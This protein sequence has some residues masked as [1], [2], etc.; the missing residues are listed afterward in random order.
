[1]CPNRDSEDSIHQSSEIGAFDGRHAFPKVPQASR[2]KQS[3]LRAKGIPTSPKTRTHP[4]FPLT[5]SVYNRSAHLFFALID[6]NLTT[7]TPGKLP[8]NDLGVRD[9]RMEGV[10]DNSEH[11]TVERQRSLTPYRA[12]LG[13]FAAFKRVTRFDRKKRSACCQIVF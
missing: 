10:E 7:G 13:V 9:R 12:L 8:V 6:P 1:M 2:G 5:T 3:G 4:P 11:A